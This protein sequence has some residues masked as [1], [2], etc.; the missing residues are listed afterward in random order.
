MKEVLAAAAILLLGTSLSRADAAAWQPYQGKAYAAQQTAPASGK[1]Y[2]QKLRAF[3]L[4]PNALQHIAAPKMRPG[5]NHDNP[6]AYRFGDG[7]RPN[8]YIWGSR[9]AKMHAPAAGAPSSD[10]PAW[11]IR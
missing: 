7:S 9:R 6:A 5:R 8:T 10:Y 11:N 1:K 2:P 3:S 4:P